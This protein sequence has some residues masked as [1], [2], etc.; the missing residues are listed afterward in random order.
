MGDCTTCAA[1]Q[2]NQ[3]AP[4]YGHIRGFCTLEKCK[5]RFVTVVFDKRTIEQLSVV[6]RKQIG[7]RL[8]PLALTS[9]THH[10][11][12]AKATN[13]FAERVAALRRYMNK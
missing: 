1:A 6:V 3:L 7:T 8:D 12:S 11:S 10:I 4:T 5:V 2:W 9:C 13:K